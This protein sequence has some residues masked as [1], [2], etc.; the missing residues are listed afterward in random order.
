MRPL[1]EVAMAKPPD[2]DW[3]L[4]WDDQWKDKRCGPDAL[5]PWRP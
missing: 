3:T 2:S 1:D 5:K 4:I